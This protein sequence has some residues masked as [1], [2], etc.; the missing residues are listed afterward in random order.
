MQQ[1]RATH[2][3]TNLHQ[4][5]Y[6]Q[7]TFQQ[8]T[9]CPPTSYPPTNQ[10][11]CPP[12]SYPLTTC[13]GLIPFQ[14]SYKPTQYPASYPPATLQLPTSYSQLVQLHCHTLVTTSY[15]PVTHQLPT[16]HPPTNLSIQCTLKATHQKQVQDMRCCARYPSSCPPSYPPATQPANLFSYTTTSLKPNNHTSS[17]RSSCS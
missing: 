12:H 5:S 11:S 16:S 2:T 14:P 3:A 15:P 17:S 9:S 8:P 1:L 6:T 13:P 7:D 4:P 10:T